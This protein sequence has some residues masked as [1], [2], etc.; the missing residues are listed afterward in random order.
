MNKYNIEDFIR[1]LIQ[2]NKDL[3]NYHLVLNSNK[4]IKHFHFKNIYKL[5]D[6]V[7]FKNFNISHI[8]WYTVDLEDTEVTLY[9]RCY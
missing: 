3:Y 4:R 9:C 1:Y 2:D 8:A 6:Y 5:H 7:I